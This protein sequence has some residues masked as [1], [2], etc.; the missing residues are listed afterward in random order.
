MSGIMN[1]RR[2][3]WERGFE[4]VTM[5]EYGMTYRAIAEHYGVTPSRASQI[6]AKAERLR[7][8][9]KFPPSERRPWATPLISC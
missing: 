2:V 6:V 9:G 3:S 8:W 1:Q 5:R 4:A 7:R